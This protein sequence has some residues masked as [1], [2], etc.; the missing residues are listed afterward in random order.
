M[1]YKVEFSIEDFPAWSGG[2]NTKQ[3]ILNTNKEDEFNSFI[4]EVF[5]D[6]IPT[7]T[8][9]ND[10]LWFE[11]DYIYEQLGLDENGKIIED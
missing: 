6:Q 8:E 10:F 1:F 4:K 3:D 7:D 9:I 11:R 2:N 5:F